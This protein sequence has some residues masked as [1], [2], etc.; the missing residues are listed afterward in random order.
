[1]KEFET[2]A[3]GGT[4][5]IIHRSHISLLQKAFEM[6]ENV[7]IGLTSD[8]FANSKRIKINHNYQQRENNLLK[9]IKEKFGPARYVIIKLNSTFGREVLTNKVQAVV[10]STETFQNALEINRK[11]EELGIEPL[12]II[13]VEMIKSD[14]GKIISSTRIRNGEIDSE[15]H[16]LIQ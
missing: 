4:F 7:I 15:G 5:D 13:P 6:G 14:D 9:I 11:R 2:V 16:M 3:V 10:T 8:Q 1:M 12:K